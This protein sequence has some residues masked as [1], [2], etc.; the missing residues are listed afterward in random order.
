M[1]QQNVDV[2]C[3]DVVMATLFRNLSNREDLKSLRQLRLK[4]NPR[5]C[6]RL[7]FSFDL[8]SLS[9]SNLRDELHPT[10]LPQFLDQSGA[11][12]TPHRT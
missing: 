10:I 8:A 7:T 12:I 11:P 9:G 5:E 1:A 6:E 2:K 3:A 4:V